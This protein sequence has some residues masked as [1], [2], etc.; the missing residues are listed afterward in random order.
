MAQ[1]SEPSQQAIVFLGELYSVWVKNVH[2]RCL[3]KMLATHLFNFPRKYV[4]GLNKAFRKNP[5][6]WKFLRK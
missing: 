6:L 3:A 5:Q 4:K 2:F 1:L